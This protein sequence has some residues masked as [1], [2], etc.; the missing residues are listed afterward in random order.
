MP[1]R[2]EARAN[3]FEPTRALLASGDARYN[4]P[5]AVGTWG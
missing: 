4:R 3:P 1:A 2:R 5:R